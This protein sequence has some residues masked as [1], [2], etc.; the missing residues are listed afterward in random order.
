MNVK[1]PQIDYNEAIKSSGLLKKLLFVLFALLIYRFGTFIPV[2]GV[3]SAVLE[4][5]FSQHQGGILGIFDMFTGGALMRF[6]IFALGVMPYISAS[7]IMTLLQT[8]FEHLK[9]LKEQGAQGRKKIQEYT[10]YFTVLL[11][12]LQSYGISNGILN[13]S[14]DINPI[15]GNVFFFQLSAII[16]MTSGTIFL[17]WLGDQISE[18]GLGSGI[19]VLIFAGIVANLPFAVVNFFDLGRTGAISSITIVFI[20]FVLIFLIIGIVFV[21]RSQRRLLVQYPKRQ[22]G[23][24]VFGGQSSY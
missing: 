17:V 23:N 8:S 21:E 15:L 2:P 11:A 12:L 1:V 16:C 20:L 18:N 4:Q 13:L 14:D 22:V 5:I 19:S 6:S 7:I 9:S 24:K 3:N 10:R